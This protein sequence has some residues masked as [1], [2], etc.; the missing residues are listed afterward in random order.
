MQAKEEG[1]GVR[2][3]IVEIRH[4]ESFVSSEVIDVVRG[5]G[6][7]WQQPESFVGGTDGLNRH[8]RGLL[9]MSRDRYRLW[10]R[11]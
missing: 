7:A 3:T 10:A 11:L 1:C 5:V 8:R 6:K 9:L 4:P 2:R